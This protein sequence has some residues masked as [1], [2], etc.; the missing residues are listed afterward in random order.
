VGL[1]T[2]SPSNSSA[3]HGP[4]AGHERGA[5]QGWFIAGAIVAMVAGGG[6]VLLALI[7]FLS[8]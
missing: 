8:A 3:D 4:G 6:H 5:A 2:A 7:D 1:T